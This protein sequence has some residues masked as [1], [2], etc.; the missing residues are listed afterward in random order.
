LNPFPP[1]WILPIVITISPAVMEKK[2]KMWKIN[3]QMDIQQTP[4]NQKSSLEKKKSH[5]IYYQ[6]ATRGCRIC[7]FGLQCTFSIGMWNCLLGSLPQL[8]TLPAEPRRACFHTERGFWR[9]SVS[10]CTDWGPLLLLPTPRTD[11]NLK[12]KS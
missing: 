2:S 4:D 5:I 3:T 10:L 1:R 7:W 11:K 12:I 6:I 9:N 8:L